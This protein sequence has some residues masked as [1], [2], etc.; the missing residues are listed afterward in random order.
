MVGRYLIP[1]GLLQGAAAKRAVATGMA[2]PLA[3]GPVAFGSAEL[4]ERAADG[5]G[6][7]RPVLTKDVPADLLA[8]FLPAP[9]PWAG[10]D[11]SRALVMGIVNVTPDSFSDGGDYADAAAAIA[12]GVSLAEAGADILDIGGEST[13]PGSAPVSDSE[14]I[15]R[16]VPVI[17]A[18]A[19]R[20]LCVSVDTRHAAVMTAAVEAGARIINDVTALT[21]DPASE[22]VAA[23][24]G[25]AIILMH[26]LGD[27][28]TMQA[29][30]VYADATLDLLDYFAARLTRLE[31][32]G[33]ER[34]RIS[35]DPGIGFGKK[36][37]HNLLILNELAAFHTFGCPITLGVSRKSFI[38]RLSRGEAPKD[39]LA[40]SV[41]IAAWGLAQGVQIVRVHDVAETFQMR[42]MVEALR[43]A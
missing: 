28:Q 8:P 9:K 11:L 22:Q 31:A 33:V 32:L 21:G 29:N 38:G 36:D 25:A 2:S 1:T 6:Q 12:R 13:R 43:R 37:P 30:P 19:E 16:V 23:A 18:L 20:G 34:G 42:A 17:K 5:A 40:G 24:S 39:R 10:F 41:A 15:R 14:E 27:P 35:L 4:A 7:R 26:M 3:G